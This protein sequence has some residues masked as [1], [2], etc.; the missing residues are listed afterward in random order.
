MFYISLCC[1]FSLEKEWRLTVNSKVQSHCIRHNEE[2]KANQQK[3]IW[4]QIFLWSPSCA[5]F[6][7]AFWISQGTWCRKM[8]LSAFFH[9]CFA[10][11]GYHP[12]KNRLHEHHCVTRAD[13][14]SMK[15]L[16]PYYW[17]SGGG[18]CP[19]LLP[20]L[21]LPAEIKKKKL[22]RTILAGIPSVVNETST[23]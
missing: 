6:R 23:R 18:R 20:I 15:M 12:S 22:Q 2:N 4:H 11:L 8:L 1:F 10:S 17:I 7:V 14:W 19:Q 21:S 9:P 5:G 16:L 13:C 3:R